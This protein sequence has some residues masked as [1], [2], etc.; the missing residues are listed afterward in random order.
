MEP[1]TDHL[2]SH[3]LLEAHNVTRWASGSGRAYFLAF[4]ANHAKRHE[5]VAGPP[6]AKLTIGQTVHVHGCLLRRG[7]PVLVVCSLNPVS[8][9]AR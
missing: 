4:L 9:I 6:A 2:T 3:D 7:E 5:A 8:Q 1:G